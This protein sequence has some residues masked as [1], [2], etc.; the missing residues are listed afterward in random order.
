MEGA[1]HG[2]SL[3]TFSGSDPWHCQRAQPHPNAGAPRGR[4]QSQAANTLPHSSVFMKKKKTTHTET[5]IEL[6]TGV[7]K[8][9]VTGIMLAAVPILGRMEDRPC[10]PRSPHLPREADPST[11]GWHPTSGELSTSCSGTQNNGP[12]NPR[13]RRMWPEDTERKSA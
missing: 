5:K 4:E 7:Y 12:P 11:A 1:G 8:G 6:K 10:L 9:D 13:G 3:G 2:V